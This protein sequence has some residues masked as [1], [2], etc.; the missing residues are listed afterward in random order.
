MNYLLYTRNI[1]LIG[2]NFKSKHTSWGFRITNS[3]GRILHNVIQN[4]NLKFLSP[5]NPKYWPTHQNRQTDILDFF[6]IN[7]LNHINRNISNLSDL[8]SDHTP[9]LLS[10]NDHVILKTTYTTLTS[11]KINWKIFS[12][13]VESQISLNISLKNHSDID[14]AVQSLTDIIK[15]FATRVSNTHTL[16]TKQSNLPQHLCQLII[17]KR[18]ARARW[19]RT[20]LNK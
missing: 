17:E 7:L 10:L 19:Q 15:N 1:Y 8:S 20:H 6:I 14:N 11:G 4:E 18:C 2:G 16:K 9:V 5:P 13:T 3:R 12:E